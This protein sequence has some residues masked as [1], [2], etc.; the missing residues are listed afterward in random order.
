MGYE[1]RDMPTPSMLS[2]LTTNLAVLHF[3][4]LEK[5]CVICEY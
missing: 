4:V 2:T 3:T 5:D 1:I